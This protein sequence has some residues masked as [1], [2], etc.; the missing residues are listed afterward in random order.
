MLPFKQEKINDKQA[1]RI[2]SQDTEDEEFKWHRDAE[3]R[4]VE[5]LEPTDWKFQFDNKLP[6]KLEGIITIPK[7]VYHRVIKG[8]GNLKV[9]IT[10]S[11]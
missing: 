9:K 3:N 2:F 6:Q 4:I 10:F 7:G 8:S 1:I 5:I 11:V